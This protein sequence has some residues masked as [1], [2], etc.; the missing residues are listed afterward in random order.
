MLL[1]IDQFEQWLH[2]R[3][4]NDR[5]ELVEALRHCDG[6]RVQCLLLVRDDFW[7]ALSRFMT[8]LEVDLVQNHNAGL[9]GLIWQGA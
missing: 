5:R 9:V 8:E 4:E 2:G 6:S 1:V 7:L 3:G